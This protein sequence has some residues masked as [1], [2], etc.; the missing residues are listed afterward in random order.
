[1][2]IPSVRGPGAG[3]QSMEELESTLVNALCEDGLSDYA[4]R[5]VAALREAT[6]E[7]DSRLLELEKKV[8]RLTGVSLT[9]AEGEKMRPTPRRAPGMGRL[10]SHPCRDNGQNPRTSDDNRREDVF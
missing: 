3:R 6:E 7:H 2:K 9:T 10:P 1:M 4:S 5:V 8:L